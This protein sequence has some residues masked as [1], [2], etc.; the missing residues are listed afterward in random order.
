MEGVVFCCQF[1]VECTRSGTR[2]PLVDNSGDKPTRRAPLQSLTIR[3]GLGVV[4]VMG[5]QL[6]VN[7]LGLEWTRGIVDEVVA[8]VLVLLG[9]F[10]IY[11]GRA[12]PDI[13]PLR[14]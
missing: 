13:K 6:I 14:R 3:S 11:K 7:W 1:V 12:N 10:G 5:V 2:G 9:A 8:A 4:V